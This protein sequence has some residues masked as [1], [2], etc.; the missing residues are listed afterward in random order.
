MDWWSVSIEAWADG[1]AEISG[2]VVDA[3]DRFVA[4]TEPYTG[5][6]SIGGYPERWSATLSIESAG[7]ADAVAEG[8]RVITLLAAEAGL[9]G[10]P[11]ARAEAIR[12]DLIEADDG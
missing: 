11:V 12:Q 6:V 4:L 10:W 2:D 5:T 8:V 9:P 1:T 3:V 7:V